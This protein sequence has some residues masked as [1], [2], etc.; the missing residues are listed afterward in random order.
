MM[1]YD[2]ATFSMLVLGGDDATA[3][4]S[5]FLWQLDAS[6][7]GPLRWTLLDDTRGGTV[8]PPSARTAGILALQKTSKSTA[9]S[10]TT[11]T[12]NLFQYTGDEDEA[13]ADADWLLARTMTESGA[14]GVLV[15][16]GTE[17]WTSRVSS[18]TN[19]D[20]VTLT[21]DAN[22]T[23]P[24]VAGWVAARP[25]LLLGLP[26][27]QDYVPSN[28][29]GDWAWMWTTTKSAAEV[30]P[31]TDVPPPS[32]CLL[33]FGGTVVK[34]GGVD[35][36]D[37]W[38]A[39][40]TGSP[41]GFPRWYEVF[42]TG[43]RPPPMSGHKMAVV[44]GEL[45]L[46]GGYLCTTNGDTSAG[47][48]ECYNRDMY[49]LGINPHQNSTYLAWRVFRWADHPE[50]GALWPQERSWHTMNS[51]LDRY[52]IVFAG[53]VI[54]QSASTYWFNDVNLFDTVQMKWLSMP[55]RGTVPHIM[56]S[57]TTSVLEGKSR[58]QGDRLVNVGGCTNMWY[59]LD[60]WTLRIGEG[61][62]ASNCTLVGPRWRTPSSREHP[63]TSRY[64]PSTP[65]DSRSSGARG[66]SSPCSSADGTPRQVC[67][68]KLTPSWKSWAPGCTRCP[69][70]PRVANNMVAT[71]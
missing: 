35:T 55:V 8:T 29:W 46:W 51:Y 44:K 54:D 5:P 12:Q 68:G 4:A 34:D 40:F 25:E 50:Q 14:D 28:A 7:D 66:C 16:G 62:I 59:M 22:Q 49:T 6:N 71:S 53:N 9:G 27:H 24:S 65:R 48:Q 31:H 70:P 36:N 38:I 56:W 33:F 1:A 39:N 57:Q 3:E 32:D 11:Y 64:A 41:D 37:T 45:W 17:S 20:F 18:G 23:L 42:T 63:P 19:T 52:L 26:P 69:S 30:Q 15:S 58:G 47:G 10:V 13:R 43:S 60:T 2:P 21:D 67:W 61:I